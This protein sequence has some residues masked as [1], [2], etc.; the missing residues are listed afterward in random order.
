[1]IVTVSARLDE[2]TAAMAANQQKRNRLARGY[3]DELIDEESYR[4][5]KA[6]LV[7]ERASLKQE[8]TALHRKGSNHGNEPAREVLNALELAVKLRVSSNFEETSCLIQ[9]VGTNRLISRKK[10][11]FDFSQPN[12]LPLNSSLVSKTL[13]RRT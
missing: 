4:E 9:K 3:L 11:S 10:G 13:L 12:F 7:F 1:M 6:A 2:I 8:R 5:A